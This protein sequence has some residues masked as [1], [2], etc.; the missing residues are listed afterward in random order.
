MKEHLDVLLVARPGRAHNIYEP[1]LTSGL[2]FRFISFKLFPK[3]LKSLT[4]SRKMQVKGPFSESFLLFTLFDYLRFKPHW[5]WIGRLGERRLFEF[6]LK[7]SIHNDQARLIHYWPNYCY[8][9]I[10]EYKR[11]HPDVITFADVYLPCEK[12]IVDEIAPQLETLGVGMNVEYIRKRADILD[13]LMAGEDNFICQSQYVANSYRKYYPDK[14]YY[15][16]SNGLTISPCYQ[17]KKHINKS[18]DIVSFVYCGKVTV[19]KGSDLLVKWFSEHPNLHIHLYGVVVESEKN[20]FDTYRQYTNIHFHGSFPKAELQKEISQYDA[21]I[22][23]SR[24]DAWSIAAGEIMGAGL[25]LVVSEQTGISELVKEYGFGEVCQL[26]PE[27]ITESIM[28]LITPERYNKCVD[29]IDKYV[30]SNPKSYGERI[31]DFYK[32]SLK[33]K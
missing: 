9:Y 3:W 15:V 12:Y 32:E 5:K 10:S 22:H 11:H 16:I 23:L 28:K 24:F 21:G 7:R 31:V 33:K 20:V 13:E 1:L 29:N 25:P 2:K 14:N 27:K 17:K 18:S 6:F 26:T 4:K 8:K 30:Q 19:E